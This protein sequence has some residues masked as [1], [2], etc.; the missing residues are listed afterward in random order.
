MLE[1]IKNIFMYGNTKLAYFLIGAM[2]IIFMDDFSRSDY[3]GMFYSAISITALYITE[4][5][6]YGQKAQ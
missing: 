6:P 2:T 1:R 5:I 3:Y 4:R